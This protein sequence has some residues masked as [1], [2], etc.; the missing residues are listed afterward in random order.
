MGVRVQNVYLA[1]YIVSH[2]LFPGINVNLRLQEAMY[3]VRRM[4]VTEG[5]K[6]KLLPTQPPQL[7]ES[8]GKC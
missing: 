5:K 8:S 3:P 6:I 4:S 2:F 7:T 1:F